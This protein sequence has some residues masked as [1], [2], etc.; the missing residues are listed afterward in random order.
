MRLKLKVYIKCLRVG[1]YGIKIYDQEILII[2]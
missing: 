1:S 2:N